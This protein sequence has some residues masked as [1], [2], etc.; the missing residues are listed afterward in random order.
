MLK[1]LPIGIQ[2]FRELRKRNA[3][4]VDKTAVLHKLITEGKYYFISRPR[5]FGKSIMISTLAEIFEGNRDLFEGLYIHDK[6]QWKEHPVI[7]VD[8]TSDS[9]KKLGVESAID[10][11]LDVTA[12]KYGVELTKKSNRG[13]LGEL[14]K[15]LH[16]KT[17]EKVALL[18]DE[19]DKP[20][21]DYLHETDT[22]V[23]HREILR[24]FYG[25]IKPMD[26]HLE[27]VILTGVSKFSKVSIFSEL[28]NL[29]DITTTERYAEI[30]GLTKKEVDRYFADYK[31]RTTQ[32]LQMTERELDEGLGYWYDGYCW[33]E[34]THLFN[35]FS[36]LHFFKYEKFDNYWFESGTP[37]FLVNFIREHGVS[38][39]RIEYTTVDG[40]FFDKFD[41]ERLDIISLL[42]Q[43]GYLT[44]KGRDEFDDYILSYPNKE[45]RL[46]MTKNLLEG[47]TWQVDS[48]VK[49]QLNDIRKSFL[50]NDMELFEEAMNSLFSDIP[51]QIFLEYYEAYYHSIAYL[52]IKLLG[53]YIDCEVSGSRGR[54]DA[55]VRTENTVYVMEFK[56]QPKTV[57]SAL[58]QI[59]EK[60]YHTPYLKDKREKFMIGITF[61][62]D[63][64]QIGE[65][66]IEEF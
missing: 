21:I 63:K 29:E 2:N 38:A 56:V 24:D 32:H 57:D 26:P 45:V 40:M 3:L 49:T 64:K 35:P 41:I 23:E 42:F 43:T 34:K 51:H 54:T 27:F 22:A 28:N 36:I 25:V 19:Y 61:D 62:P 44:I 53:M 46:S 18:V 60:G 13:R 7:R 33:D 31:K 65:M 8:F 6:I 12:E 39:H 37:T 16:D 50:S 4:Y 30:A 55:V 48:S 14:I 17:G 20:I 1:T 59:K 58:E 15:K 11:I 9:Y 10:E 47:Y 5:R 66:K 52:V